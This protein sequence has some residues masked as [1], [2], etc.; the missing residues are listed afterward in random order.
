MVYIIIGWTYSG[1]VCHKL[2]FNLTTILNH[3]LMITV[4]NK[5]STTKLEIEP[6]LQITKK[7][8]HKR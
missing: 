3:D 8:Y 1:F 7:F 6:S 4:L 2:L 5:T